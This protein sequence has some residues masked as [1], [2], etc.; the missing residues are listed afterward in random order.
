MSVSP[1]ASPLAPKLLTTASKQVARRPSGGGDDR[2]SALL[3]WSALVL[4][5]VVGTPIFLCMPLS[6]DTFHYDICSRNLLQGGVHYKDI[7]DN[8]LP[9]I[10][11]IQAG[12]RWLVGWG[13]AKL[14]AVDLLI[15]S[16]SV[17]LLLRWVP[18][19][20]R[21]WTA[22]ALYAFYLLL[23]ESCPCERDLWMFLPA[24]AGLTLRRRQ[25]E[26]LSLP[27]PTVLSI[28]GPAVLEGLC[29]GAAVWIKPFVFVP[30]LACWLV[31]LFLVRKA[32][33]NQYR[34][35]I[36][37]LLGLL[38]GGVLIGALG[39]IALW[40][41]GS[42]PYFLEI[43]LVWNREYGAFSQRL[44]I[45]LGCVGIFMYLYLPW[46]LA[47]CAA[48]YLAGAALKREL[49]DDQAA[50]SPSEPLRPRLALLAAF[51]FGWLFQALFLQLPHQYV[52]TPPVIL[53]VVLIGAL[54]R[55]RPL[56]LVPATMRMCVLALMV[57]VWTMAFQFDRIL[58]WA[59][60][61]R[62]GSTPELQS[63]LVMRKE[64][65]YAVDAKALADVENYLVRQGARDGEV[66]CM[67]GCT[68]PLY[69]DLDLKPSTRFPQVEMTCLFFT[70]H[71]QEV[72]DEVN[73]SRQRFIVSDLVWTGLTS[74]EAAETNP[75]DPLAL[76]R[77]FPD[78]FVLTYPWNEPI[79][80]RSGR[81]VVQ[82]ATGPAYRFWRENPNYNSD[83][84]N[85]YATRYSADLSF[86]D[87]EAARQ[88]VKVIEELY[89]HSEQTG[90]PAGL[91]EARVRA[92][93][94]FDEARAAGKEREA[95]VFWR[96]LTNITEPQ[97]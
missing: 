9:G 36:V 1:T 51:F 23:P 96:W 71:R 24:V 84:K 14:L 11:W 74:E 56:S 45:R 53:A 81:Y 34:P 44:D 17:I 7:F 6:F 68:H 79:V 92:L 77:E 13:S 29:W 48:I 12:V 19:G 43:L 26:R 31:S 22:A 41:S 76:P 59:R 86:R 57:L 72:L 21:V 80:F 60:C 15:F 58:L 97:P 69:L 10:V 87:E 5:L 27:A 90:D 94:M 4:V 64:S 20:A 46:S 54:Y 93:T 2:A 91:H 42:W 18:R 30:G 47:P 66:T 52:L 83:A 67:S 49:T 25:V 55:W 88:S 63:H 70:K 82:R 8:N 28:M 39:L 89:K 3:G 78:K 61:C 37:D 95:N 73:A 16:I 38:T 33:P 62:E 32:R 35:L 50:I 85:D 40:R 65:A 75:A